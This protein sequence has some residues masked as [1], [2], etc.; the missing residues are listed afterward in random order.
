M[1]YIIKLTKHILCFFKNPRVALI[2][3]FLY[4]E[5]FAPAHV[6]ALVTDTSLLK[7]FSCSFFNSIFFYLLLAFNIWFIIIRQSNVSMTQFFLENI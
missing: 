4:L 6:V 3:F 7:L 1:F 5:K 2:F